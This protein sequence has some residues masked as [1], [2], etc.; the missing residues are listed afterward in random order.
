MIFDQEKICGKFDAEFI[1]ACQLC[2]FLS[3]PNQESYIIEK[4][5]HLPVYH[6][7]KNAL[8]DM[9]KNYGR[10]RSR[11]HRIFDTLVSTLDS[12]HRTVN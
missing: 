2:D 11:Q 8:L 5:A 6:S 10:N 1:L 3:L 4:Y 9:I 12:I 7:I